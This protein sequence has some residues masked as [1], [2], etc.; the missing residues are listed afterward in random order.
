ML[1]WF[2][3]SFWAE[4]ATQ[5]ALHVSCV[6]LLL[7]CEERESSRRASQL[8]A[9]PVELGAPW[10]W[11]GWIGNEDWWRSGGCCGSKLYIRTRCNYGLEKSSEHSKLCS[12]YDGSNKARPRVA[13]GDYY[14]LLLF[15][16]SAWFHVKDIQR[17]PCRCDNL[18]WFACFCLLPPYA[19]NMYQADVPLK[20]KQCNQSLELLGHD[21]I[22]AYIYIY[23]YIYIH[24]YRYQKNTCL[25]IYISTLHYIAIWIHLHVLWSL[26]LTILES[27][28]LRVKGT[29]CLSI[30]VLPRRG[31]ERCKEWKDV[32]ALSYRAWPFTR[33]EIRCFLQMVIAGMG[34]LCCRE[35]GNCL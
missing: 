17:L 33:G 8:Q 29:I 35:P 24:S 9:V 28:K 23:W 2:S 21:V 6:W 5:S 13:K 26:T 18:P 22:Y 3:T 15:E 30:V 4:T 27:K 32:K 25:N 20:Y 16:N 31:R 10:Q 7:F 19:R 1:Q 14:W 34:C 11:V 12:W